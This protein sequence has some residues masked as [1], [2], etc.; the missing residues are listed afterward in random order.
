[1]RKLYLFM[2]VSLDGYFEGYNHDLSWHNA[3]NEEFKRLVEEH[4]IN[5]DAIVMGRVTYELMKDFWPTDEALKLEPETAAFMTNTQKYA[6]SHK[7]F[8]P[9]WENAEVI[10]ENIFEGINALKQKDGKDIAIFGSNMLTVSLM[11]EGLVDEFRLM[12]NPVA[13][14]SGTP[15]FHGIK[16]R[17]DLTLDSVRKYRSGN[18]LLTY[19]RT[20]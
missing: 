10:H 14:G 3:N 8:D 6:V 2:M 13:I 9:G 17:V 16:S 12:V 5:T 18:V 4:S 1:M 7:P 19:K 11:E 15:L 20:P